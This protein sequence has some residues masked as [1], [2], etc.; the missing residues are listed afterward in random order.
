[1]YIE[2]NDATSTSTP[3]VYWKGAPADTAVIAEKHLAQNAK[4]YIT[5]AA[6][7]AAKNV[8][9]SD[10]S[11]Q[12]DTSIGNTEAED[13]QLGRQ[14][15]QSAHISNG[16]VGANQLASVTQNKEDTTGAVTGDKIRS[17]SIIERHISP[18]F[19]S[20]VSNGIFTVAI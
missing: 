5:S 4:D 10:L 6:T 1:M 19:T 2:A 9:L 12:L 20:T 3:Y 14:S 17:Y 13:G 15:I 7:S 8:R 18:T 11:G 16:A